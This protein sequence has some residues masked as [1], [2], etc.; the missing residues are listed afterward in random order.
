[1]KKCLILVFL[2]WLSG[3]RVEA[4]EFASYEIPR[5]EVIP[6]QDTHAG[7]QYELYVKLPDKYHE[8]PDAHYPVIYYTDG[9]W[10]IE[11]LYAA[12]EFLMEDAILVGISWQQDMKEEFKKKGAHVSRFWDYSV[13]ESKDPERQA[14]YQFGQAGNHL[15]FLRKDVIPYVEN[16]YRTQADNRS[17]F[18]YSLGGVFGSYVLLAQPDT[19]KNYILG[20]PSLKGDI[21]TMV[22]LSAS[23]LKPLNANVFISYGS[24]ENELAEY[25]EEFITLLKQRNDDSLML[26]QVVIDGDHQRASPPTAIRALNWLHGLQTPLDAKQAEGEQ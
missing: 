22:K 11:L 24:L 19:F 2:F 18:G 4:A 20:S 13:R 21:P 15:A 23:S 1:M 14:K 6:I 3:A 16:R 7:K 17:Y 10:H 25:V 8:K 26:E 12:T 5:T 9:V